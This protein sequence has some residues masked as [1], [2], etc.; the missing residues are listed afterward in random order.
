VLKQIQ[1][2]IETFVGKLPAIVAD[3]LKISLK[4]PAVRYRRWYE[5]FNNAKAIIKQ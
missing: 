5:F 3:G 2:K 1:K 4:N